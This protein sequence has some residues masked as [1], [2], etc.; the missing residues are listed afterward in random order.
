[1]H[2]SAYSHTVEGNF[3]ACRFWSTLWPLRAW[4]CV[5]GLM[6]VCFLKAVG[7]GWGANNE[8]KNN[9]WEGEHEHCKVQNHNKQLIIIIIIVHTLCQTPTANTLCCFPPFWCIF[10]LLWN[11]CCW[12]VCMQN[13]YEC[14]T[15]FPMWASRIIRRYKKYIQML[16]CACFCLVW[17]G[18][19]CIWFHSWSGS[20]V[21]LP[22]TG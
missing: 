12:T 3:C 22:G 10:H 8:R 7:V 5:L 18:C 9:T 20:L 21:F 4:L 6:L 15:R 17:H 19:V 2:N 11:C 1:M 13:I 14:S 16:K